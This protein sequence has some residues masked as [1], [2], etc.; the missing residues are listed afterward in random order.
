VR[1]PWEAVLDW[2]PQVLIVMPCGYGLE[3]VQRQAEM[4]PALPGWM[5]LPAVQAGRAFAVDADAYFARPGP[6]VV[7]GLELLAH[8]I[9]PDLFDWRG[10]AGAYAHVR[11]KRCG[12]CAAP[13][14]CR[15]APGCWCE[16]VS[17]P[18]GAA[19]RLCG[20]FADCL[21]PGCLAAVGLEADPPS[22]A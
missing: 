2:A 5:D 16:G 9:Q 12:R 10:D 8:L 7:E 11:T 14:A 21:C 6:R 19:A 1:V 22:V 17:L 3:T 4:L 20:E 15:P 13:F 18:A